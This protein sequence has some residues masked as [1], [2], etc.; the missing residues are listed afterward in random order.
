[1]SLGIH[2]GQSVV[3]LDAVTADGSS[4][5]YGLRTTLSGSIPGRMTWTTAV[6]GTP[7]AFTIDLE[8]SIDGTTYEILD[9]SDQTTNTA[10]TEMRHVIN[11]PVK[12]L[13]VTLSNLAGGTAPTISATVMPAGV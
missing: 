1:M 7:T 2:P 5:V 3:F 11:K 12:Y 6:T 4:A 13:R 8:G 9:T 10:G